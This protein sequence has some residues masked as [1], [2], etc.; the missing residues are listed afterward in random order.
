[1]PYRDSERQRA[2]KREWAREARAG[3][4]GTRGGTLAPVPAPLRV[5]TAA[6][7]L[8]L[9][10][11]QVQ[12]VR[13]APEVSTT[14]RARTLGFLASISLRAVEAANLTARLEAVEA[15]LKIRSSAEGAA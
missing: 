9:L 12:A 7:V 5:K 6:D 4:R 11:E 13:V 8:A 10:A 14:E 3:E 1:M 15:A 2:A